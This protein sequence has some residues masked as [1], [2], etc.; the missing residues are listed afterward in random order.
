[1]TILVDDVDVDESDGLA[2]FT[3]RLSEAHT[4]PVRVSWATADVT[5]LAGVD[6]TAR[7]GVLVFDPGQLSLTVEV[8]LL[9]N[10]AR[11]PDEIFK[12]LLT[13]PVNDVLGRNVAWATIHDDDGPRGRPVIR[14]ADTV[15]D[16]A[17]DAAVFTI[18][19]D[20]PSANPV[21]VRLALEAGSTAP[22]DLSPFAPRTL[23]FAPGEVVKTVRVGVPQQ[24]DAW[25]GSTHFDLRLSAPA[26]ADLPDT[27]ARA[28]IAGPS[29]VHSSAMPLV[30]VSDA[31]AG[32]GDGAM[33]F[34]VSLSAR[35][36]ETTSVNYFL[37]GFTAQPGS[38]FHEQSGTLVFAPGE[39][40]R[41][42]TVPVLGDNFQE[43]EEVFTVFLSQAQG[44]VIADGVGDALGTIRDDDRPAGAPTV[45]VDDGVVD[46]WEPFARFHVWLDR[47]STEQ[48]TVRYATSDGSA[49]AGPGLGFND[50]VDQGLQTLVFAPGEVSK[51][52]LVPLAHQGYATGQPDEWSEDNEFFDLLLTGASHARLGDGIA[53]T[54]IPGNEPTLP[55]PAA[56]RV[57]S[58]ATR[59]GGTTLDFF[60]ERAYA[61]D[62]VESLS[63]ITVAGTAAANVDYFQ[64]K[65]TVTFQPGQMLQVLHVPLIN[66]TLAEGTE[67]FTLRLST[68][69][70]RQIEA[71]GRILDDE[72][73]AGAQTLTGAAD[74]DNVLMGPPGTTLIL[75]G[76]LNDLL[77]GAGAVTLRGGLGNDS[78]IADTTTTRVEEA[79]NAG[80][81]T[82]FAYFDYTLGA[83][84]EVLALCGN[85]VRGTGNALGNL[86]QGS[87]RANVLGGGDGIDN[88][89]GGDGN[90]TLNGD[91]DGDFL[92]GGNGADVVNGGL[93]NDVIN[94]GNDSSLP[95]APV[96]ADQ[97]DGGDGEDQ[98][99]ADLGRDT[100]RGGAGN[101]QLYGGPDGSVLDG[102][103][104]NDT[105]RGLQGADT[106]AG[107]SG[108]DAF[109]FS[110]FDL[111]GAPT[112]DEITDWR[113]VDDKLVFTA[114][115]IGDGDR[116][117]DGALVRGAP[118]GF[119]TAAELVIFTADLPGAITAASAAAGIGSATAAYTGDQVRM[120][121]VDNGAQ[122][123]VFL[124]HNQNDDARV[125]AD[126]L[127]LLVLLDGGPTTVADYTFIG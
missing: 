10:F 110:P 14:V 90:D 75:G 34:L 109:Y 81:D 127:T 105:L 27:Q 24:D 39:M 87:T 7:A 48:V 71:H 69:D 8:P 20:R 99:I 53:H 58:A 120:F 121:T 66:D 89:F 16:D 114:F 44:L 62:R 82:V 125:S 12:L 25:H 107:G 112:A 55:S 17:T 103:A 41:V 64:N 70:G 3:L 61:P 13:N 93:G 126:E 98:L 35:S 31:F 19:L 80:R 118:G 11:E 43:S 22:G 59:E 63:Y 5:A 49:R 73:P 50:Y 117:V 9:N 111:I 91:A 72:R 57:V 100:L 88:I 97:L 123:G 47:P 122:S 15:V 68:P 21:S 94:A 108:R 52:V 124:F 23:V 119:S 116:T 45:F 30:S 79:F 76:N 38:D 4:L 37:R 33:R 84:L 83:N 115:V 101:D 106:M 113:S 60:I 46:G 40:S 36:D 96:A 92:Y 102:G 26:G 18:A 54:V 51:T 67:T 1:M 2:R 32:E 56:I 6:Y 29:D 65:G 86:L 78:Y 85:A 42:I 104:G 74:V 95:V 28:F 77:D